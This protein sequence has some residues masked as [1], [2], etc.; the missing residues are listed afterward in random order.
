MEAKESSVAKSSCCIV[1][2]TRIQIQYP[3]N[4][5]DICVY[6]FSSLRL[7]VCVP[8]C[9]STEKRGL[10]ERSCVRNKA[11]CDKGGQLT[12]SSSQQVYTGTCAYTH[13]HIVIMSQ[14]PE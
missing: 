13:A 9:L 8:I 10:L 12:S 4:K 14:S 3:C 1:M 7:C 2:R 6:L 11:E 5:Q